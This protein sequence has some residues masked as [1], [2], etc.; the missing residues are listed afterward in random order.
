M[1]RFLPYHDTN[2]IRFCHAATNSPCHITNLCIVC[3]R[4]AQII[5]S[6]C[7]IG[8]DELCVWKLTRNSIRR[9]VKLTSVTNNDIKS[10]LGVVAENFRLLCLGDILGISQ[11]ITK[12]IC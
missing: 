10:L 1:G 9:I 4:T 12:F 11:F 3:Y 5:V 6:L 7:G 2:F 8:H